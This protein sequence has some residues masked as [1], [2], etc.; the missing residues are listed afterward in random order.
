MTAKQ[1]AEYTADYYDE[2]LAQGFSQTIARQFTE[3]WVV[4][5]GDPRIPLGAGKPESTETG[6]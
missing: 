4:A 5:H 2:L 1:L 6:L 3:I